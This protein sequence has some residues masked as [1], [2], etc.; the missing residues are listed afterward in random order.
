MANKK[1]W[2]KIT[3]ENLEWQIAKREAVGDYD[4]ASAVRE[5]FSKELINSDKNIESQRI[6]YKRFY[7]RMQEVEWH[8]YC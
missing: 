2:A 7:M 1:I 4:G 5:I 3:I 8:K 6:R